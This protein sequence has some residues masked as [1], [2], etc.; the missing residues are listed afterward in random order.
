MGKLFLIISL[1]ILSLF[2]KAQ[3]NYH[4]FF[5]GI[6]STSYNSKI[7]FANPKIGFNVGYNFYLYINKKI[8][9]K[10]G[11]EFSLINSKFTRAYYCNGFCFTIPTPVYEKIRLSRFSIPIGI[12]YIL[13]NT[14]KKRWYLNCGI[15]AI[16]SNKI[17]RVVDY[18]LPGTSI[19]GT[20]EGKQSVNFNTN[21]KIGFGFSGGIGTEIPLK[22]KNLNIELQ[23]N[24]DIT[25]NSFTTLKNI[26][27]DGFF[28]TK[29]IGITLKIGYTFSIDLAHLKK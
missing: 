9:V 20:F 18:S 1:S 23:F 14:E 22:N 3:E 25:N 17:N 16:L 10:T 6:N 13:N 29:A 8:T 7:N 27:D 21:S 11:L 12:K 2:V 26:E 5:I 4:S 19:T 28:F 15:D 24:N